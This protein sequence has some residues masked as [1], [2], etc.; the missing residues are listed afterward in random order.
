MCLCHLVVDSNVDVPALVAPF[1]FTNASN[2]KYSLLYRG[3]IQKD[4]SHYNTY[5]PLPGVCESSRIRIVNDLILPSFVEHLT[6]VLIY[7]LKCHV[8]NN[9]KV[10]GKSQIYY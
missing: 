9:K 10:R 1:P 8:W 7:Y 2:K 5:Y 3:E 6:Y 4:L